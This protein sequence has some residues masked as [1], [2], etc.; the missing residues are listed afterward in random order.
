MRPDRI[1]P[2]MV[3]IVMTAL[4][5]PVQAQDGDNLIVMRVEAGYETC[6]REGFW[7]PLRIRVGNSGDDITGRLIVRPETSG[8]VVSN[9]YSTPIDLPSGSEKAAF[10][11]IQ[12]RSFPAEVT[13]ELL[14]A[15][16]A[17]VARQTVRLKLVEPQDEIH[18]VITGRDT[19]GI[20][21]NTVHAAGRV[22]CQAR[23]QAT[24]LPDNAAALQAVDTLWLINADTAT[25]TAGQKTALAAWIL[26]GGHLIV[27]GGP[28][29]Q[30][31]TAGLPDVLPMIPAGSQSVADLAPL[32][33]FA[34]H[35]AA[36]NMRTVIATGEVREGSVVLAATDD[37]LPLLVRRPYGNGTVD[38]LTADPSLA[39]LA[40]WDGSA[41]LWFAIAATAYP[42][43]FW[44]QGYLDRQNAAT[45]MA[46]LPGIELLPPVS[47]MVLFLLA[48]ILMIGPVNYFV[49]HRLNRRGFAWVTI[50]LCIIVFSVLAW[51]VGFNLRG[52]DITVSR[53]NVIR[54]W[55]DSDIAQVDE[56]VSIL[57]PRRGTYSLAVPPGRFLSV[58]PTLSQGGLLLT[59]AA[60]STAEIVQSTHFVAED[61]SVDGGIFANFLVNG[62]VSKPDIS[63][64]FT[65]TYN[66][67]GT[68]SLQGAIRNDSDIT[69]RD[70]VLLARGIA[71]P[72]EKPVA[73]GD[74]VT[75]SA[76]DLVIRADRVQ[77]AP[78]PLELAYDR[79][80]SLRETRDIRAGNTQTITG[81]LG[82][83]VEVRRGSVEGQQRDRFTALL[84]AFFA[85]QF[86]ATGYGDTVYLVAQADGPERDITL[87]P[88]AVNYV[89]VDTTLYVIQ[90]G[91]LQEIPSAGTEVTIQPDR[92][93]WVSLSRRNVEGPGPYD[94]TLLADAE[95]VLSYTPLPEARLKN[96]T[97]L[98]VFLDRSSGYGGRVL[99]H[100]WDWQKNS[101][102]PMD[103]TREDTYV[104]ANPANFL[105]VRNSIQMRL[106]LDIEFGSAWIRRISVAHRGTF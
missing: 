41:D 55:K 54:T 101:W 46:I 102:I 43:P 68:Q 33:R 50:P 9:A 31:T 79:L 45:A 81:I 47:S 35:T 3:L 19:P 71:Y 39:P 87:T 4:V 82:E 2:L 57:A 80:T 64:I 18:V 44:T 84:A 6:F 21:L 86:G 73:P 29:W 58:M 5:L 52:S 100:L 95:V 8:R 91:V 51:T 85:D 40:A 70:A 48:Y 20:P 25:L 98:H 53:I 61:F 96:V 104:V 49:L 93:T 24:N 72:L 90:L 92:F 26:D 99:M 62:T 75:F 10:L 105:N 23:W 56:L 37:G 1:L 76:A 65:L 83:P 89:S 88:G 15:G 11:Y 106:T 69:L 38:Y 94:M 42:R 97:E 17:R 16:H 74:L 7:L 77:P 30:D 103:D 32:A 27:T 63:G 78:S 59:N 14:D 66:A 28:G 34:G 60:Q 12:A 36:L 13:V 67:D 22:A